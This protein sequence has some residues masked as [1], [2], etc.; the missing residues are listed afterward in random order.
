MLT[1]SRVAIYPVSAEGPLSDATYY[2]E[3]ESGPPSEMK[4][5]QGPTL[6]EENE[7]R[8]TNQIAMEELANDTGGQASYN[9]NGLAAAMAR[10]VDNS[11]RY[12]TLT[13]SPTNK[14]ADGRYRSIHVKVHDG[15]Y[16][17][18]HRSGYYAEDARIQESLPGD[19]L[20]PL[21]GFGLPDFSEILYKTRVLALDPQPANGAL[22]GSN[23]ELK[24]QVHRYGVDF[25]I[26]SDDLT[27]EKTPK[28][29]RNAKVEIMLVA[30]DRDGRPL[31][32]K[33][34]KANLRC[35]TLSGHSNRRTECYIHSDDNHAGSLR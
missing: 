2:A 18:A 34:E 15:K 30:Y 25:A 8:A 7:R 33:A 1:P 20:L 32:L 9:T 12:Y 35:P 21:L 13:Y 3:D 22:A 19:R 27:I 14:N 26:S 10:I 24:G 11:A 4:V 31:N 17:L 5:R 6:A 28:G 23:T 29:P 16:R